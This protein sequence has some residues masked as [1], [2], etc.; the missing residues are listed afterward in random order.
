MFSHVS[1]TF[2]V[3]VGSSTPLGH[4]T[5]SWHTSLAYAHNPRVKQPMSHAVLP[6]RTATAV[7]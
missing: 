3:G 5:P 1:V 2:L 7:Q 4:R 6:P